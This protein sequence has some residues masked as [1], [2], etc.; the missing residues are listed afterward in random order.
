MTSAPHWHQRLDALVSTSLRLPFAWG[1]HDCCLF[2]ANWVLAA[3]GTDPAADVRGTY[4]TAA[5]ASALVQRLGGLQA[6]GARAGAA[7]APLLA[8]AGDVGLVHDG[9]RDLLAVCTGPHWVAPTR[10][11]LAVLPFNT[12]T[13]A[14]RV[15]HG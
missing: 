12:A 2:A 6:L 15:N 13:L 11:G 1:V 9:E 10:R 7:V 8:Q 3:T 5:Q 4:S 14:W